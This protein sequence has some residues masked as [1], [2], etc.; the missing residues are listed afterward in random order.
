MTLECGI[1][2]KRVN[3]PEV[4]KEASSKLTDRCRLYANARSTYVCGKPESRKIQL[5]RLSRARCRRP[6]TYRYAGRH[7]ADRHLSCCE[8]TCR[9]GHWTAPDPCTT[10]NQCI[11]CYAGNL[12]RTVVLAS[13]WNDAHRSIEDMIVVAYRSSLGHRTEDCRSSR[14]G[15]SRTREWRRHRQRRSK[16]DAVVV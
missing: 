12:A 6:G 11:S 10:S 2:P 15:Y 14:R 3:C 4:R 5:T 9:P 13:V 8:D 1:K 7:K 16:C